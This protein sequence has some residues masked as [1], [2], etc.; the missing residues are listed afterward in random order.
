MKKLLTI[1]IFSSFIL[2]SRA[3]DTAELIAL[4]SDLREAR[5]MRAIAQNYVEAKTVLLEADAGFSAARFARPNTF[6]WYLFNDYENAAGF[7]KLRLGAR[8][9]KLSH[10]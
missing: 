10:Q 6:L 8:I 1:L 3:D 7:E 9:K 2:N 4:L 5:E